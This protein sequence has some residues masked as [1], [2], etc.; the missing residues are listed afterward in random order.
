MAL[1]TTFSDTIIE[2][3]TFSV[4]YYTDGSSVLSNTY[5]QLL[6]TSSESIITGNT[7]GGVTGGNTMISIS[8]CACTIMSNNFV[9]GSTAV[10]A[11]I[12]AS[13]TKDQIITHNVFDKETVDGSTET[14]VSGITTTSQYEK[15]K[16]Q[17]KYAIKSLGM[18][19]YHPYIAP[20]IWDA[21]TS[22]WVATH[23]FIGGSGAYSFQTIG[24]MRTSSAHVGPL[25]AVDFYANLSNI[26]PNNVQILKTLIGFNF[27]T[28][29]ANLSTAVTSSL[30]TQLHFTN[31]DINIDFST[32]ASTLA[33]TFTTNVTGSVAAPTTSISGGGYST[34]VNHY[35]AG[36]YS[37]NSFI[38]STGK[39]IIFSF[40]YTFGNTASTATTEYLLSP[41]LIKYRWV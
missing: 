33:G 1:P 29:G 11:Y 3:N 24:Y 9:R 21:N 5:T 12:T 17:T 31:P 8:D 28:I 22:Y 13:G 41:L 7:F 39:N 26:L 2:G 32:P 10:S 14:L 30:I 37:A 15:N 18:E 23:D 27:K 34:A 40:R 4:G 35:V 25:R 20:Y 38:T 19:S 16:N 6:N 36:D